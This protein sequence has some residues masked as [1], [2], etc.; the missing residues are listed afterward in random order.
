[1][2]KSLPSLTYRRLNYCSIHSKCVVELCLK[3]IF[4]AFDSVL[5]LSAVIRYFFFF[6]NFKFRQ[7]I[8][9]PCFF[10]VFRIFCGDHLLCCFSN[11]NVFSEN[12]FFSP[13]TPFLFHSRFAVSFI[14]RFHFD[15]SNARQAVHKNLKE[16][17][18]LTLS[19]VKPLRLELELFEKKKIEK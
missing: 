13:A 11:L 2:G 5:L 1:M 17:F 12:I 7:K 15:R 14:N 9:E 3:R 4:Q 16:F 18:N 10:F 19:R 8:A 6:L